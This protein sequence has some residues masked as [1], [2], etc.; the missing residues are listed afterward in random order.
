MRKETKT[1]EERNYRITIILKDEIITERFQ[2]QH[3]A[4]DT[5]KKMKE[6]FPNLFI[7]GA[8]E[9]K[10]KSWSVIWALGNN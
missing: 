7:G 10:S 4:M 1:S 6:L 3:I 2:T 8:L 9:E 5:I